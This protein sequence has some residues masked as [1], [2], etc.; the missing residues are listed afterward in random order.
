MTPKKIDHRLLQV[1]NHITDADYDGWIQER[2]LYY[3]TQWDSHYEP[4]W[5]MNDPGDKPAEGGTLV[6]MEHSGFRPEDDGFFQ[7]AGHGWK[8]FVDSLE[9]VAAGLD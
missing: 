7:G 1:P 4:I 8:K 9:R 2:G 3:A 6:R 5:T